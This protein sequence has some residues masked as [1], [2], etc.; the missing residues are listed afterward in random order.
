MKTIDVFIV[1]DHA[2]VIGGVRNLLNS[3]PHIHITGEFLNGK[4]LL[5]TLEHTRP[6][7]LLLDV[8][9]PDINGK[10]LALILTKQYPDV[11]IIALTSLD[12]PTHVKSMMRNGCQG[13]LLKNADPETLLQAI[14]IVYEG[15]QYIEPGLE[16][17][18]LNSFLNFKSSQKKE[19]ANLQ[20]TKLT[21]REKEILQ[22]LVKENSNQ[23]IADQLCVSIRTV[24]YHRLS[25]QKKLDTK[26]P[27]GLLKAAIEMGLV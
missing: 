14:D 21:Q 23:D 9:L 3:V 10:D 24:E 26:T 1:D 27:M 15:G 13:Y 11:K 19:Q 12:A 4:A 5:E 18:M 7:I 6:D 25:L 8:L 2:L 17:Q 16:K 22:L 20:N